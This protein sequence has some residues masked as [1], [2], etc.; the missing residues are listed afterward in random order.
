MNGS[1][2]LAFRRS[3]APAAQWGALLKGFR[4]NGRVQACAP[5]EWE[6]TGEQ[7]PRSRTRHQRTDASDPSSAA[8]QLHGAPGKA[9]PNPSGS[10][11]KPPQ[12]RT[13]TPPSPSSSSSSSPRQLST[14]QTTKQRIAPQR[15]METPHTPLPPC[16]AAASHTYPPPPSSSGNAAAAA[17]TDT[18]QPHENP[19]AI[20][21]SSSSITQLRSTTADTATIAIGRAL[22]LELLQQYQLSEQQLNQLEIYLD[23][24][25]EVNQ[26]MNLTAV[27]DKGD[28]WQR[29]VA[30]SLALLPVIERYMPS[31]A[32]AVMGRRARQS[33]GQ[34][35]GQSAD[36]SSHV[37]SSISAADCDF[38]YGSVDND[39]DR[40][41]T[42]IRTSSGS[43]SASSHNSN[44]NSGSESA[45]ACASGH[46]ES[47]V[48]APLRLVD[49][50]TGA[51]LPGMVLAVA[52]PQWKV[53]LLDSLRKRCDFLQEAAARAGLRNVEVVWC[54]AEE[55]GRR[56]E[57]RQHC[58]NDIIMSSSSVSEAAEA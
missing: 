41:L 52:R 8:R 14:A 1:L 40:G 12:Q 39:D 35:G 7:I 31:S 22:P 51:G 32:T 13:T 28:A 34:G 15:G 4:G 18:L 43:W 19:A 2:K 55:G 57:L 46:H 56:P 23:Y 38:T 58:H 45:R 5:T 3:C 9:K 25:L 42:S 37:S 33:E 16:P 48:V 11:F 27:R 44:S 29:H 10:P 36:A 53:T 21:A 30:D 49:V 47:A 24:L 50:G 54:R 17:N 26:S 6:S 20:G